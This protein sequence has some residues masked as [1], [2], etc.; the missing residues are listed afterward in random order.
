LQ[1]VDR[2]IPIGKSVEPQQLL[3]AADEVGQFRFRH[4]RMRA[5]KT[6]SGNARRKIFATPY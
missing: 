3:A 2:S 1:P 4:A 6:S 5:N